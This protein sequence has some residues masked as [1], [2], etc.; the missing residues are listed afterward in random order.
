MYIAQDNVVQD[1]L[2]MTAL[3]DKVRVLVLELNG[4]WRPG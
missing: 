3:Q 2:R 1:L 4:Q